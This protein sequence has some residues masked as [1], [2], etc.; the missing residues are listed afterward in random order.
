[1]DNVI[2]FPK[3]ANTAPEV[4]EPI[5]DSDYFG[6]ETIPL[7]ELFAALDKAKLDQSKS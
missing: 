1:M 3:K 2:P 5:I 4:T 7:L 6:T